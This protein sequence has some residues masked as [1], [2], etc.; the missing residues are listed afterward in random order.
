MSKRQHNPPLSIIPHVGQDSRRQKAEKMCQK[1]LKNIS[2]E[3]SKLC[4]TVLIRNTLKYVQSID[5]VTFACNDHLELDDYEPLGKIWCKHISSEDIDEFL[6]EILFP[7]PLPPTEELYFDSPKAACERREQNMSENDNLD[8]SVVPDNEAME[9]TSDEDYINDLLRN[10]NNCTII[11]LARD[12][13]YEERVSCE[14][15]IT[16]KSHTYN[17]MNIVT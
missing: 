8:D 16:L 9:Y 6:S 17:K 2:N 7:H 10:R 3:K 5:H 1:K 15:T 4:Q 14:T 13:I 11:K 12:D